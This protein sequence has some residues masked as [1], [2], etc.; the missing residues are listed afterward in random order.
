M[1]LEISTSA[2]IYPSRATARESRRAAETL[3]YVLQAGFASNHM[4]ITAAEAAIS[5]F[6]AY[7]TLCET[8]IANS[9]SLLHAR[10]QNK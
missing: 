4:S 1:S 9:F 7:P 8:R 10:V 6:C 2:F 5:S 3:P